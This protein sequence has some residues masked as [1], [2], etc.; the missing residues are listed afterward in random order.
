MRLHAKNTRIRTTI[1]LAAAL[2]LIG[3]ASA[4]A[5]VTVYSNDL[6]SRG[7]YAALD[8]AAGGKNACERSYRRKGESML[9][10]VADKR[11]CAWAPP[12]EGDGPRP[13]H[14]VAVDGRLLKRTKKGARKAAYLALGVRV[15]GGEGYELQVRPRT[16]R[17]SL[18]RMPDGAGFPASGQSSQIGGVGERNRL[19]LRA[20]GQ[21][22]TAWV[23]GERVARVTDPDAA[24]FDGRRLHF[25]LGSRRDTSRPPVAAFDRILVRVP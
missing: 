21:N 16:R 19:R 9:V 15:G 7:E 5:Y 1:A 17:F 18:V 10:S 11:L 22:V 23:N 8:R 14:E 12:V 24:D 25:G 6:S 20:D 2:A 3:A 4:L 13:D